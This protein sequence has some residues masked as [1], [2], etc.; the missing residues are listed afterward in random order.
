MGD[1]ADLGLLLARTAPELPKHRGIT[2]FLLPMD[3]PGSPFGPSDSSRVKQN[4]PKSSL[5]TLSS[6]IRC[7][8]ALRT[9]G[10]EWLR[11]C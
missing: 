7:G 3:F 11:R 6:M 1:V 9:R 4:S 10:G 5:M 8:S 2:V